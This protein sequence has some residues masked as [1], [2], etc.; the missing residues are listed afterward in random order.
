MSDGGAKVVQR[1]CGCPTGA[2]FSRLKGTKG[3]AALAPGMFDHAAE[4]PREI[5]SEM[6]RSQNALATRQLAT[7]GKA[8]RMMVGQGGA[9]AGAFG[10]VKPGRA[11]YRSLPEQGGVCEGGALQL[12]RAKWSRSV[13]VLCM[14]CGS[15]AA[16]RCT[17]E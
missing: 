3:F 7:E 11:A 2:P 13:K 1:G 5:G 9:P 10:K 15:A 4:R 6:K 8:C 16:M 12:V 17:L 14:L